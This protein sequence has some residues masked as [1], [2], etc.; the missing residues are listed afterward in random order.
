MNTSIRFKL[1]LMMFLQFFVWGAWFVTL[2]TYLSGMSFDGAEIGAAYSTMPWGA[3][4]APFFVG[5][6]ADRFFN[7]ERVMGICHLVGAAILFYAASVT[8]ANSLFWVLFAYAL[9][10]NPTLAL[11]NSIS[12][13]QMDNSSKQFPAIR[14]WGPIGWIAAGLLVGTMGIENTALPMKI[15]AG[16][17]V[18]LGVY[19]FF[20]PKTPPK[21]AGQK[22]TMRDVLNLDALSLMKD[23]SFAVFAIGSMLICIPLAFYYNF[24]NLFLNEV[25]MENAAGKMTLG[26]MSEIFFMVVMPFFLVRL[27][28]KKML[29]FGMLAWAARYLLFALGNSDS[30]IFM[31]YSGIILHGIC[32]DFFFVTGHI[33]VDNVAPKKIQASAQGFIALITYGLGLL[34]GTKISGMVVKMYE[35]ELASGVFVH[36]WKTIWLIPA[37]MAAVIIIVFAIFFKEPKAKSVEA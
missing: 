31:F 25:G 29:L 2:G 22:V 3:L 10:Y 5:M 13:S 1:S 32:Y 35:T 24:T 37:V 4:I 19:S 18:V 8:D 30:L 11:V 20:L 33:H 15:A 21:S 28:I 23:R 17:S 36:D 26:Q 16:A 27:G 34:I 14:V 12:F 9:A 6:V 7:S